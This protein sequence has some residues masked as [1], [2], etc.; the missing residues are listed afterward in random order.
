MKLFDFFW[1]GL[2]QIHYTKDKNQG[3]FVLLLL[4]A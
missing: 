3:L 4:N 2:V 1:E